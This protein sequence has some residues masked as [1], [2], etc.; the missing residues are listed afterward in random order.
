MLRGADL[1]GEVVFA[2]IIPNF[3]SQSP[4]FEER[5]EGQQLVGF[6]SVGFF[7]RYLLYILEEHSPLR[8][9]EIVGILQL[10]YFFESLPIVFEDSL[11]G[12]RHFGR[13]E[14]A[15]NELHL[16]NGFHQCTVG[17]LDFDLVFRNGPSGE[18]GSD[19]SFLSRNGSRKES[20]FLFDA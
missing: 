6:Q 19:Q 8:S 20:E 13:A 1:A 15:V 17:A 18:S 7:K 12:T 3:E 11:D 16:P 10:S 2:E 4:S 14:H 5:R 9:H